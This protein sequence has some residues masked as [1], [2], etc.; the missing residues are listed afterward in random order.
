[1]IFKQISEK[2]WWKQECKVKE[3]LGAEYMK[4]HFIDM[5]V[6]KKWSGNSKARYRTVV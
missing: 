3:L 5:D 4:T 2:Q 6:I 1:M